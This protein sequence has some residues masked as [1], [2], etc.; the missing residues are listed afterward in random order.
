MVR[1]KSTVII[2]ALFLI[3][4]VACSFD[5][6]DKPP[7]TLPPSGYQIGDTGPAGGIICYIDIGNEHPWTYLEAWTADETGT[8]QWKT[9]ETAT[10]GT[11]TAIGTGRSNTTAMAGIDHPAAEAARAAT[12]GGF[13][14]WFVP[15]KD[16]LMMVYGQR[17]NIG[18]LGT[19]FYWSSSQ[20]AID[21]AWIQNFS[22][23]VQSVTSKTGEWNLRLIRAF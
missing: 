15:A 12:Y 8:F 2:M 11:G 20:S 23:G 16:E 1:I 9:A 19:G 4:G 17:V 14:D 3:L 7:V 13:T 21:R 6:D 5:E 18:G 10:E 22:D